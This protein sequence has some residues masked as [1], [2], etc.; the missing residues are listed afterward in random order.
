MATKK[1]LLV[2]DTKLFL[3]LE[4][5]F[6]KLSPVR[7]FTASSGEEALEIARNEHPDLIFMDIHMP[8]MGGIACCREVKSDPELRT[9]PVVMVSSCGKEEDLEQC[10]Q[11]G[12]DGFLTKPVDRRLFLEKARTYLNTIERRGVRIPYTT[13]V[14]CKVDGYALPAVSA[15]LSI[16]GAYLATDRPVTENTELTLA[17]TLHEPEETA[18][19]SKGRVAWINSGNNRRKPSLPAGFGVEFI[20]LPEYAG[21]AVRAFVESRKPSG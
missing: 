12:C 15:D 11:A 2:D 17:F 18:I 16:G 21:A 20:E 4:K 13:E 3:E 9:I 10:R 7:I 5:N 14:S 19:A 1:I 6:L 8:G